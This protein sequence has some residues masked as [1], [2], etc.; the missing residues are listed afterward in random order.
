MFIAPRHNKSIVPT[1]VHVTV[2][3]LV[4]FVRARGFERYHGMSHLD[5]CTIYDVINIIMLYFY[6]SRRAHVKILN[7]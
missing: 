4:G 1:D 3:V 6:A 2:F 7:K 5:A